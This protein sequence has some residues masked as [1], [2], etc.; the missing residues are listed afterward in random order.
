[1]L[2]VGACTGTSPPPCPVCVSPCCVQYLGGMF[3]SYNPA[4]P[5]SFTEDATVASGLAGEQS[6][7]ETLVTISGI[8]T[9]LTFPESLEPIEDGICGP[10]RIA[11]FSGNPLTT[12]QDFSGL[13]VTRSG[14]SVT[15]S[16]SAIVQG[17]AYPA[18]APELIGS[19]FR[20]G[21]L[22][23]YHGLTVA[24]EIKIGYQ[25][26]D[27]TRYGSIET[28][29]GYCT[30]PCDSMYPPTLALGSAVIQAF[31][32][33]EEQCGPFAGQDSETIVDP[34]LPSVSC[35]GLPLESEFSLSIE[36][37]WT[38]STMSSP[39]VTVTLDKLTGEAGVA[40]DSSWVSGAFDP[41][42][43]A[44]SVYEGASVSSE[45][46]AITDAAREFSI[47]CEFSAAY[48]V[49]ACGTEEDPGAYHHVTV[50]Y[51]LFLD[52]RI[53]S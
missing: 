24:V 15:I 4:L 29:A 21:V 39:V 11:S 16:G 25:D 51:N 13:T 9:T 1:M 28:G 23:R 6:D 40:F 47:R 7:V 27:G 38:G 2:Y 41:G 52:W 48:Y 35:L 19:G 5:N 43:L 17:W 34:F 46:I 45:W 30:D 12:E 22:F 31:P 42:P 14:Q 50:Y 10:F 3:G 8:N 33:D 36:I 44:E 26:T 32:W 20:V 49:G 18:H 37:P 53:P